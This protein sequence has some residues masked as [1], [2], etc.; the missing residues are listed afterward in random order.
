M[1]LL[2]FCFGGTL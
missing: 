2:N 1:G